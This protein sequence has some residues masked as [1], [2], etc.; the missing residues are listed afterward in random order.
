ML[1]GNV[2]FKP[3]SVYCTWRWS[4]PQPHLAT[5]SFIQTFDLRSTE[6]ITSA[7][8][9]SDGLLPNT[10]WAREQCELLPHGALSFCFP[11]L[12]PTQ[13]W[14]YCGLYDS[15]LRFGEGKQERSQP[16]EC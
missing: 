1:P 13:R 12:L 15:E 10:D 14:M 3:S 8:I 11:F 16:S 6:R 4:V 9:L 5:F 7:S 2:V